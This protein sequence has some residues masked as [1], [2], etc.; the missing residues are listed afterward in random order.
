[1]SAEPRVRVLLSTFNG[2]R[3]LPA[4]LDSVL[5]QRFDN[6]EIVARDDGSNDT[7]PALLR[8]YAARHPRIR[9]HAGER[10]GFVKSFLSL[11]HIPGDDVE[12]Y[13][14]CDQDDVWLAH[15]VARAV[16]C[17]SRCDDALPVLYCSRERTVTADLAPLWTSSP[18]RHALALANALVECPFLGCTTVINR[19]ARDLIVEHPPQHACGHEWWCYLVASAF[20]HVCFDQETPVLYRRHTANASRSAA[21]HARSTPLWI[22]RLRRFMAS[23]RNPPVLAQAREFQRLFGTRL[24]T[25]QRRCLARFLKASETLGGRLAYALSPDVYRQ[26]RIENMLLRALIVLGRL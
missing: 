22:T 12:Y 14:F 15:K 4:L 17:S 13:A 8:D 18:P 19:H 20:G 24:G 26:H 16:E 21:C 5:A 9:V 25:A 11:L 10:I 2:E 1:M 7:T 3:Y 23:D 6:L